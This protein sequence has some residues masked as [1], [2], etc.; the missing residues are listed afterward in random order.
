MGKDDAQFHVDDTDEKAAARAALFKQLTSAFCAAYCKHARQNECGWFDKLAAG[1]QVTRG[2]IASF[3]DTSK[4]SPNESFFG[5][6][7]GRMKSNTQLRVDAIGAKATASNNH[8]SYTICKYNKLALL[9]IR[10]YARRMC[11]IKR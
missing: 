4:Y 9:V 5:Q 7:D 2:E 6:Y 11:A 3:R 1:D 10:D 8:T